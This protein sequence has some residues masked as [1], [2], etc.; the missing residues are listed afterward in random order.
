M[1][2]ARA[3]NETE[4]ANLALAR[5]GEPGIASIDDP[6]RRARVCKQAF[7]AARDAVLRRGNW[8]FASAWTV[9]VEETPAP[10]I[11][12]FSHRYRLPADCIAVRGVKGLEA[13]AWLVEGAAPPSAAPLLLLTDASAPEVNYTA[14]R[15]P[16]QWDPLFLDVFCDW[17]AAEIAP[18]IGRA[19]EDGLKFRS[20]AESKLLDAK[21]ADAREAARSERDYS[22]YSWFRARLR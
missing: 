13:D 15:D 16:A 22:R 3:G 12:R 4:V 1:S 6:S 11:G 14:I 20:A 17:F 10:T 8:N 21:K 7:G 19:P 5:I 9:P 2:L 18:Q